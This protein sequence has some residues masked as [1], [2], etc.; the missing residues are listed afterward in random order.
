MKFLSLNFKPSK[1]NKN[2]KKKKKY[3]EFIHAVSDV[4]IDE[5]F[6]YNYMIL[7][8]QPPRDNRRQSNIH[9][10]LDF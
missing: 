5:P 7:C 6:I 9:L 4:E 10:I 1:T 2:D 3:R 8:A